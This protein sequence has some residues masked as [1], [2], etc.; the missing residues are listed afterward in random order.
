MFSNHIRPSLVSQF[1]SEGPLEI[2]NRSAERWKRMT[3]A[4]KAPYIAFHEVEQLRFK[5]SVAL[6]ALEAPIRE[7]E[8]APA[9][10]PPTGINSNNGAFDLW[11][12]EQQVRTKLRAEMLKE[13]ERLEPPPIRPP[14]TKPPTAA[15]ANH[16]VEISTTT[17]PARSSPPADSGTTAVTTS[18]SP[19]T[20]T[21]GSHASRTNQKQKLTPQ[22]V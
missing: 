1:P 20:S 12:A 4:E 2:T 9:P 14:T 21:H 16:A 8:N 17:T 10:N 11:S 15:A 6:Y 22:Q 5:H 13:S 3:E 7:W 18:T 19:L